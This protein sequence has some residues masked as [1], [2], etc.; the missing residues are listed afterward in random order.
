MHPKLIR[1]CLTNRS[2][3]LVLI[4]APLSLG[5]CAPLVVGAGAA[6]GVAVVQE[7]SVG[8][9]IDDTQITLRVNQGLLEAE[10]GLF[11]K[12]GVEVVEGRVLLT[13]AV[14]EAEDRVEA[15]RIAWKVDG[16]S[17]VLNEVQ[18]A[19]RGGITAYA[20]DIRISSQL[21]LRLLTDTSVSDINYSI[22][23]VNGVIYLMGISVSQEELDTVIGY[24]R[25]ISGVTEVVSHVLNSDD[26]RRN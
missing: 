17:E 11:T 26:P 24:A 19:D 6:L 8:N 22:D 1:R 9:A 21:R 5:A 20:N 3:I 25:G 16:V 13:G 4:T 23:T 12:V 14:P 18:I 2:L 15:V 10:S 7:R